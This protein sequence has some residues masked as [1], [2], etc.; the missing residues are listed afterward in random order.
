M[1]NQYKRKVSKGKTKMKGKSCIWGNLLKHHKSSQLCCRNPETPQPD[2]EVFAHSELREQRCWRGYKGCFSL[3]KIE[4]ML[5]QKHLCLL[6]W[7]LY[8]LPESS[9]RSGLHPLPSNA[10]R[11]RRPEL[12]MQQSSLL[13]GTPWAHHHG[14]LQISHFS[15]PQKGSCSD[16]P[17]PYSEDH[18]LQKE[19]KSDEE[20]RWGS[21]V[22]CPCTGFISTSCKR[23]NT[24]RKKT[25]EALVYED[26]GLLWFPQ[27]KRILK[28]TE[29]NK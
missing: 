22:I 26:Q 24:G 7:N 19:P 28:I 20:V 27:H 15:H 1:G 16:S 11:R 29:K 23:Q 2:P 21:D 10:C 4:K 13:S 25:L 9:W 3:K 8:R 12:P 17:F 5:P 18:P 6:S 14:H